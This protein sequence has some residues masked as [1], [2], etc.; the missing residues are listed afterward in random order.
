[1][2]KGYFVIR[3]NHW[4]QADSLYEAIRN[5]ELNAPCRFTNTIDSIERAFGNEVDLRDDLEEMAK[6]PEE[7]QDEGETEFQIV[8]SNADKWKFSS[9][10][11]ID[12]APSYEWI[13]E[14]DKPEGR[15]PTVNLS[16]TLDKG[17]GE[18]TIR[19]YEGGHDLS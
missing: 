16:C 9:A 10:S 3:A 2:K 19:K 15:V 5:C 1:M 8:I 12:G 7:W 11:G 17:T 14:D 6:Y 13:G 18:I 4:G